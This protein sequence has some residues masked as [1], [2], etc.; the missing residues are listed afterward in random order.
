MTPLSTL[1][2]VQAL[3][4]QNR[5]AVLYISTPKCGVC[6]VMKPKINEILNDFD[7]VASGVVGIDEVPAL[8][9]FYH[10][11]TAPALLVF[12]DGKEIWRGAR[13]IDVVDFEN[14]LAQYTLHLN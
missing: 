11:L 13:F 9:S 4:N 10:I 2:Q 12:A 1:D 3:I 6:T 5:L 7:S 14:T 8:A